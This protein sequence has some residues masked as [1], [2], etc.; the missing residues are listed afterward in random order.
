MAM[1]E[2]PKM[3]G[4]RRRRWSWLRWLI[5]GSLAL[6]AQ[7]PVAGFLFQASRTGFHIPEPCGPDWPLREGCAA[8]KVRIALVPA[9]KKPADR[10]R[11]QIV[12]L[13]KPAK[14]VK[15]PPKARHLAEHNHR[16]KV[17]QKARVR[18]PGKQI[19]AKKRLA[20]RSKVQ[21]P[22]SRDPRPTKLRSPKKATEQA[23][24]KSPSP[25]KEGTI[26]HGVAQRPASKSLVFPKVPR[27]MDLGQVQMLSST[28]GADDALPHIKKEGKETLLNA[29]RYRFVSF[30]ERVKNQ[31]RPYWEPQEA[32]EQRDP[33]GRA[34]CCKDRLTVLHVVLD[35]SGNVKGL[36]VAR[37]SGLRFLD[38]EARR[39]FERGGP[40]PNPPKELFTDGELEFKFGFLLEFRNGAPF[41][42]WVPPSP[43]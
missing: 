33:S 16:V 22:D 14:E 11:G 35:T 23:S 29:R 8:K 21:S 38:S 39:A 25:S 9:P 42:K 24:K 12:Q 7:L 41:V 34:F 4:A 43:L 13:P 27:S 5:V 32:L 28:G 1:M 20:R 40:F 37:S 6:L 15:P 3:R 30:F 17:E 2:N 26:K 36:K 31:V 19:R 10:P 18:T